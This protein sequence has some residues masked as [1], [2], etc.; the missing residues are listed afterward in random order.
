MPPTFGRGVAGECTRGVRDRP[1][2][3]GPDF[4]E[5]PPLAAPC[6]S[7]TPA[8]RHPLG[9]PGEL[10]SHRSV[11][12]TCTGL[13]FVSRAVWAQSRNDDSRLS[14]RLTLHVP[15]SSSQ[16]STLNQESDSHA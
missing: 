6:P 12:G 7:A 11:A 3:R 14:F 5:A 13:M 8:T 2:A 15:A 9:N 1:L 16:D 4:G 10:T